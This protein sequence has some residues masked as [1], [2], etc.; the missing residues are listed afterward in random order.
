MAAALLL[1]SASLVSAQDEAKYN[2]AS[3]QGNK[4]LKVTPG[5]A[6]E[7]VIYFYNIEGNRITHISLEISKTPGNWKVEIDPPQHEIQVNVS[8][9]IVTV[10]ENLYI[11]P[12]QA[13]AQEPEEVPEGMVYIKLGNLGYALAKAVHI[14]VQV[15]ETVEIGTE[16]D[17]LIAAEAEWLG[18]TGAAA[19]KQAREFKFFVEVISGQTEFSETIVGEAEKTETEKPGVTQPAKP[20]SGEGAKPEVAP[21]SPPSPS[22]SGS[23]GA[24]LM[25]WLP[26]IIAGVVVVLAAIL[27]LIIARRRG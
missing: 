23:V 18:Q 15:P 1:V 24:S 11:E 21:P 16:G 7:G 19:I 25:R 5:G 14:V 3:A 9:K 17:I 8:G 13:V 20:E 6:S 10:T 26:A 12:S 27:I 4:Q 22:E 2:F